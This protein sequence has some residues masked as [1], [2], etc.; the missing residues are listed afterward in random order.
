MLLKLLTALRDYFVDTDDPTPGAAT[1]PATDTAPSRN[2][3]R[4]YRIFARTLVELAQAVRGVNQQVQANTADIQ[5][6]KDK[7]GL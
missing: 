5:A 1:I 2:N 4:L 7:L 3:E 6:I